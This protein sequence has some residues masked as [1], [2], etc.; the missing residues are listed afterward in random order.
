MLVYKSSCTFSA[1]ARLILLVL[2]LG[3]VSG[4]LVTSSTSRAIGNS[5][6]RYTA[7]LNGDYSDV[8]QC[9]QQIGQANAPSGLLL[10][11]HIVKITV[12]KPSKTAYVKQVCTNCQL[13]ER[14]D[15]EMKL[16]QIE[17]DRVK[18][19][20]RSNWLSASSKDFHSLINPCGV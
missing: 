2:V 1:F 16:Q 18:A 9:I 3:T 6:P 17:P 19:E 13:N 11:N 10:G 5:S 12:L 14:T 8:A 4:C 20:Y 15:W 7:T